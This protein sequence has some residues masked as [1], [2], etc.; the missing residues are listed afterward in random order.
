MSFYATDETV[1]RLGGSLVE[2]SLAAL[3]PHGLVADKLA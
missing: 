2:R 3:G 1:G